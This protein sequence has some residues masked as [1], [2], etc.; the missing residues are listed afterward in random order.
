MTELEELK[1]LIKVKN[2][3]IKED[4]KKLFHKGRYVISIKQEKWHEIF[5]TD[6][7]IAAGLI[8]LRTNK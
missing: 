1:L 2:K 4:N 8:K 6:K 7:A 5:K 3:L